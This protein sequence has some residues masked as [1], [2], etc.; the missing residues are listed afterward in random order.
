MNYSDHAWCKNG[1]EDQSL[2]SHKF[3]TIH[4]YYVDGVSLTY[5]LSSHKHI[6]TFA[7]AYFDNVPYQYN[8]PFS[9]GSRCPQAVPSFVDNGYFYECGCSD[10]SVSQKL[11]I[12]DPS[13]D[14]DGCGSLEQDCC[15]VFGLPCF[16]KVLTS[17]TTEALE[18]RICANKKTKTE[19]ILIASY[20][21]FVKWTY[22]YRIDVWIITTYYIV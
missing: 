5:G 9:Y 2:V 11:Y 3:S 20:E 1:W 13:W 18:V 16:P 21:I 14:R 10:S 12:S 19:D 17:S 6:W 8:C 15:N 22:F 7:P 4:S